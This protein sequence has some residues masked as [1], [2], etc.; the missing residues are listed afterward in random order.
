MLQWALVFF[1][2]DII[3]GVLGFSSSGAAWAFGLSRILFFVFLVCFVVAL[4]WGLL[5][6]NKHR[7]L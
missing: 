5:R 7:E 2:L 3:A 1:I 4:I 6:S